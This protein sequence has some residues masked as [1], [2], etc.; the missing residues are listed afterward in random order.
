MVFPSPRTDQFYDCLLVAK[1]MIVGG[2]LNVDPFWTQG[3]DRD[4]EWRQAFEDGVN[5]PRGY[6]RGYIT[7][8]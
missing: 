3:Y 1:T 7:W 2:Q 4:T 6:S 5:R 8:K